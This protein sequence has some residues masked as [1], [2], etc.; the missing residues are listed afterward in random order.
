MKAL[1]IQQ[2]W[3]WLIIHGGKDIENRTWVSTHTGPLLIHAS[4]SG[5]NRADYDWVENWIAE[6]GLEV[7]LP[8]YTNLQRGGFIGQVEMEGCV[9]ESDSPWFMGP[10]GFVL[11]NPEP[12]PFKKWSGKLGMFYV[13]EAAVHG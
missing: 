12:L 2:P 13:P 1:S 6:K 8:W 7:E 10:V 9:R 3:A 4:K 5:G 11:K